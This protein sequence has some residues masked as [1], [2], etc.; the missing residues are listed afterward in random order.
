MLP[1]VAYRNGT[2]IVAW[3]HN[4]VGH[5]TNLG[6]RRV[7]YRFLDGSA[8]VIATALGS[9]VGW[10]AIGVSPSDAVVIAYTR[11]QAHPRR[12]ASARPAGAQIKV[13]LLL[14]RLPQLADSSVT[15]EQ[16]FGGTFHINENYSQL[17]AAYVEAEA[18]EIPHTLPCEIYC[19]SLSDPSVLGPE[20][21][22]SGAHTLTVFGLHAPHKLVTEANN[23]EMRAQLVDAV[24]RSLNSVLA[25]PI[26]DVV[27]TDAHGKP[28]IEGKTTLDLEHALNM[29]GGNI[30][31]GPLSW[32]WVEDDADLSTAAA[33]WGV[34]TTHARVLMC[35]SGAMRGGA[36]SGL[37]GHNA[38][39]AVMEEG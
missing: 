7:A 18:G 15:P 30:F 2:A 1:S 27:L 39:M 28:C 11:A 19:H 25:E 10:V 26:E 34:A 5:F 21:R 9:G 35:G 29:T 4:P 33:R 8:Q 16:A 14:S 13:N 22:A 6:G 24:I 36:V 23:D 12:N 38:A 32:P 17:E 20:L 31:H 37:G 3:A